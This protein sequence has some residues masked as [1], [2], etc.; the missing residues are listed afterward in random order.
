MK[1]FIKPS[2]NSPYQIVIFVKTNDLASILN[3][4]KITDVLQLTKLARTDKSIVAMSILVSRKDE[5]I[6]KAKKLNSCFKGTMS[7]K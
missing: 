2:K 5:L 7:R 6:T 4:R 1:E 3:V